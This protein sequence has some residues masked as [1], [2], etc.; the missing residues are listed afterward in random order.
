MSLGAM[1]SSA[2]WTSHLRKLQVQ[3]ASYDATFGAP[4]CDTVGSECS[5]GT[6]L[7]GRGT[8]NGGSELNEPN[9]I[10]GCMDGNLGTYDTDESL[11]GIV[12]RSG[13]INGTGA[14]QSLEVGNVAT[15]V[16]NV[17]AFGDGS[18]DWADFYYASDYNPEW[19]YIGTLQPSQPGFQDLMMEY[20]LPFGQIQGVRV[21]YRFGGDVG[22]CSTGDYDDRDDIFFTAYWESPPE[23]CLINEQ[24]ELALERSCSYDTLYAAVIEKLA[25]RQ[26]SCPNSDP[27][28]EVV[29]LLAAESEADAIAMV[30]EMCKEAITTALTKKD[31]FIFDRFS[32]MDHDFNKAF[33]DGQSSWNDGGMTIKQAQKQPP[34]DNDD[35][36]SAEWRGNSKAIVDIFQRHANKRQLA[37][38]N[39][40]ENFADCQLNAAMCC[41]VDFD[42]MQDSEYHN[43]TEICYVDNERAPSSNHINAG[44][45]L[46]GD[47]HGQEG[48]FCHGFAWENG[49]LD[50]M[51]KGNNLFLSEIYENM[52]NKGL[53]NNVPGKI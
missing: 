42:D 48:A 2:E 47:I 1:G 19:T 38:P 17:H 49:S 50:D 13:A 37:W 45:S 33:F 24:I 23:P 34:P 46:Y 26:S 7:N 35:G 41:W 29:S 25:E 18:G 11:E 53:R 40:Y 6:L 3:T 22:S 15:I 30:D 44:F 32:G 16:A 12:V 27:T 51:F 20:T 28:F 14:G 21:N 43:N 52:H 31:P 39:D 8:M 10:D 9:T 36:V 5:S 4:F